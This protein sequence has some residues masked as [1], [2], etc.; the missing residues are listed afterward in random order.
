[1][2]AIPIWFVEVTVYL[3]KLKKKGYN[4]SDVAVRCEVI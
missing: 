1:M 4:I 3:D 2:K